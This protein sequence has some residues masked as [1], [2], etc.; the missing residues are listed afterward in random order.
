[1]SALGQKAHGHERHR[2]PCCASKPVTAALGFVDA[3][4]A[5]QDTPGRP[6]VVALPGAMATSAA[7]MSRPWPKFTQGVRDAAL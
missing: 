4:S 3:R 7:M 6:S 1:M 2:E 5:P